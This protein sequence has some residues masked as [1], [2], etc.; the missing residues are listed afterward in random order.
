MVVE[1]E[2]KDK[3]GCDEFGG[4]RMI[5]GAEGEADVVAIGKSERGEAGGGGEVDGEVVVNASEG[6]ETRECLPVATT[7]AGRGGTL[8]LLLLQGRGCSQRGAAPRCDD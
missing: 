8:L 7:R 2:D 3:D 6:E 4:W 5:A 1:E